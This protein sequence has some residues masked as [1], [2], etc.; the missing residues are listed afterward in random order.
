MKNFSRNLLAALAIV[1]LTAACGSDQGVEGPVASSNSNTDSQTNVYADFHTDG[2]A[3]CN[4]KCC[5]HSH[6]DWL[7]HTNM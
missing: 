1:A 5:T 7:S 4:A 6:P 3:D 2:S